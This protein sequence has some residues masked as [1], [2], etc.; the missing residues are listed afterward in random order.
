MNSQA[1]PAA[2]A[3][4]PFGKAAV[5][6]TGQLLLEG[7]SAL[8]GV[9]KGINLIELDPN[10]HSVGYGGLPNADGIVELDAAI[11]D[12]KTHN[13]GSVAGLKN[14]KRPISVARRV[15]EASPHAMLVGDGALA[16]AIAQ[17]FPI[18]NLLTEVSKAMWKEWR[19]K[20]KVDA[21][22]HDTI[23]LVALDG[24]GDIVAGCSTSGLGYK[25]PGRVG[26]S[27]LIGSG[28]YADNDVGGAAATGLGEIIL[29]FCASFLVVEYMRNW[30]SPMD[31]CRKTIERILQKNP[32]NQEGGI[33]LIALNK[34]GEF[35]AASTSP[36]FPYAIWTPDCCEVRNV[37]RE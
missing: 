23:G 12:G 32:Q 20:Q 5:E 15:M 35:G 10:E 4:W 3:T 17:G 34:R 27:P 19:Q 18:E 22:S 30:C 16:F 26:D 6:V 1:T 25:L 9:E 31:A 24:H 33:G 8:D 13:A 29:K 37:E 14:I 28:L 7:G 21:T 36:S 2:I 11:M